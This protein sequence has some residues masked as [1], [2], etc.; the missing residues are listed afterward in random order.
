MEPCTP[1]QPSDDEE[2]IMAELKDIVTRREFDEKYKEVSMNVE[3]LFIETRALHDIVLEQSG[4]MKVFVATSTEHMRH[5]EGLMDKLDKNMEQKDSNCVA[6]HGALITEV[7]GIR[8]K[9]ASKEATSQGI[10]IFL[11]LAGVAIGLLIS[12]ATVLVVYASF[13]MRLATK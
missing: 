4:Q 5:I 13:F 8:E 12:G 3:T 1:H 2:P 9:Q 7:G 6:R 11:Q 10:R